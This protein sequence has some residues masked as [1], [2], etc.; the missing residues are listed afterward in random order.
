MHTGKRD[1]YLTT[2][3]LIDQMRKRAGKVPYSR[4]I[5]SARVFS[6]YL[7]KLE[8]SIEELRQR[9]GQIEWLG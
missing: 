9:V 2:A 8:A 3:F 1:P 4:Y 6:E 7:E 5:E